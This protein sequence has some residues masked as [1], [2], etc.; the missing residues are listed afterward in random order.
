M[1]KIITLALVALLAVGEAFAVR[2]KKDETKEDGT[3]SVVTSFSELYEQGKR[4]GEFCL[5]YKKKASGKVEWR[6]I[7]KVTNEKDEFAKGSLMTLFAKNGAKVELPL[8]QDVT[9]EDMNSKNE[10]QLKYL[11]TPEQ[12]TTI[13]ATKF[14]TVIIQ[15]K[16]G[17]LVYKVEGDFFED[18]TDSYVEIRKVISE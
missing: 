4:E 15:S 3:R 17:D 8:T 12:I 11:L 7:V 13:R 14:K 5:A 1:K 2:I 18:F 16:N 6:I 10:Q 9:L